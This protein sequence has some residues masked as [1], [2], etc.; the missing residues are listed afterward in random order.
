MRERY[1]RSECSYGKLS[2]Y[3]FIKYQVPM[4]QMGPFFYRWVT[5]PSLRAI[6]RKWPHMR[7]GDLIILNSSHGVLVGMVIKLSGP[8]AHTN[9]LCG[10]ELYGKDRQNQCPFAKGHQNSTPKGTVLRTIKRCPKGTISGPSIFLSAPYYGQS[11]TCQIVLLAVL[12]RYPFFLS[13][14]IK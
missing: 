8:V 2:P 14:V 1:A 6:L 12:F 13:V 9:H 10:P 7:S 3:G 11:N 5:C 4:Q